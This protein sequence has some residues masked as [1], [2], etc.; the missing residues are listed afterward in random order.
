MEAFGRDNVFIV[1]KAKEKVKQRSIEW[2]DHHN[3]YEI[4]GH[5]RD[6][7]FFCRERKDKAEICNKYNINSFID[8]R[9]DVL[10]FMD[11]N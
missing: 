8:D 3:F 6:N 1:S 2:L 10:N 4:T 9:I 11:K 7:V 5:S